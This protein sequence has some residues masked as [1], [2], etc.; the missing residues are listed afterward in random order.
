MSNLRV[1]FRKFDDDF[2]KNS[3]SKNFS[4]ELFNIELIEYLSLQE[5]GTLL[6]NFL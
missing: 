2:Y 3:S 1:I 6:S 5:F 4:Q